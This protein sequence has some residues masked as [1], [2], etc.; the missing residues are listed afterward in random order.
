MDLP[1][2]PALPRILRPTRAYAELPFRK[3][4]HLLPIPAS[5]RII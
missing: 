3:F 1:G 4:L 5:T 2:I